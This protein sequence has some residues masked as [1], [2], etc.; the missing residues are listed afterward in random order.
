[1]IR[2]LEKAMPF[3]LGLVVNQV[4]DELKTVNKAGG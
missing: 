2:E 3:E 4:V 1:M